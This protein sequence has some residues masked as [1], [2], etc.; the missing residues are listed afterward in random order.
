[1]LAVQGADDPLV[2]AELG[3]GWAA[4]S[5]RGFGLEVLPGGHFYRQ[6][7][8]DLLPVLRRALSGSFAPDAVLSAG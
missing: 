5:D 7:L 1:V 8:A 4:L 3:G 2:T 6:G